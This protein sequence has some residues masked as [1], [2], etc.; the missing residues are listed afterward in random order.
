MADIGERL[1]RITDKF[2]PVFISIG[3]QSY[4]VSNLLNGSDTS[5]L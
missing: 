2:I 4:T 3:K 1:D 5:T